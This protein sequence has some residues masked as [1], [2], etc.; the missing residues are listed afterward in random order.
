VEKT[1]RHR[2]IPTIS[3]S[4]HALKNLM[5]FQNSVM[6]IGR[7]LAAA[8]R[9]PDQSIGGFLLTKCHQQGIIH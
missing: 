3:L 2:I 6:V 9:V 4:A 8:I 1:F 7:I 5:L